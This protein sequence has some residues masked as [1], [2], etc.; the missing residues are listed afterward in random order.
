M[1]ISA[2]I[3]ELEPV[4][5]FWAKTRAAVV[6]TA[7]DPWHAYEIIASGTS[8][9]MVVLGIGGEDVIDAPRSRPLATPSIEITLGIGM[10]MSADSGAAM[11]HTDGKRVALVDQ[12]DDLIE[13]MYGVQVDSQETSHIFEY[14]GFAPLSLPNGLRMAAY[15]ATFHIT[16]QVRA[17]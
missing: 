6:T 11:F 7:R 4:L 1:K 12:L 17:A 3:K 5:A 13:T 8:G 9:L 14:R 16:R 2:I 10:G 15:R